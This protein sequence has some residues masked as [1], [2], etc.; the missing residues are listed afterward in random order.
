[1]TRRLKITSG[2]TLDIPIA[3]LADMES[4]SFTTIGK[5]EAVWAEMFAETQIH[6]HVITGSLKASGHPDTDY[7]GAVWRGTITYGGPSTGINN[8]V[9]YAIYEMARGGSHNF[10]KSLPWYHEA[11]KEAVKA[12]F[13]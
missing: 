8:P 9:E 12:A 13:K 3:H 2:D 7:D 4:P 1:M 6:T 5:L 11:L 10:F